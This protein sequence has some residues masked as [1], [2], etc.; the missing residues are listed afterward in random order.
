LSGNLICRDRAANFDELLQKLQC[1]TQF[2]DALVTPQPRDCSWNSS[3]SCRPGE[4]TYRDLFRIYHLWL[5]MKTSQRRSPKRMAVNV[6]SQLY[7]RRP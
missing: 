4:F 5:V 7:S 2:S 6:S 3:T 1:A